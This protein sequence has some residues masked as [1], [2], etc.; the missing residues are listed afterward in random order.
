MLSELGVAAAHGYASHRLRPQPARTRRAAARRDVDEVALA[1]SREPLGGRRAARGGDARRAAHAPPC[2]WSAGAADV[3]A[4]A[5]PTGA[6]HDTG[7]CGAMKSTPAADPRPCP[8][9]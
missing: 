3:D 4:C 5:T 6:A 7:V 1:L 9:A 2:R 8:R